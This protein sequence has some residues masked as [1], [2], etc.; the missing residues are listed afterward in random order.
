MP[1][2]IAQSLANLSRV[3]AIPHVRRLPVLLILSPLIMFITVA[4]RF[5]VNFTLEMEFFEILAQFPKSPSLPAALA[6]S[7]C[8]HT[9]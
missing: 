1:H 9:V 8:P 5:R 7:N 3:P 2:L 6:S 4:M